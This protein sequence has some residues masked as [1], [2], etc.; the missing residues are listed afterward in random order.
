MW[1]LHECLLEITPW[2]LLPDTIVEFV[3]RTRTF[4]FAHSEKQHS[5]CVT[6]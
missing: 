2:E 5:P 4:S 6:A 3:L 1:L